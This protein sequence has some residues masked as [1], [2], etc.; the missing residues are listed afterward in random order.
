M[1]K[2]AI[3]I[4]VFTVLL[5][6]PTSC[7]TEKLPSYAVAESEAFKS[8]KDAE[9]FSAGIYAFLRGRITGIFMEAR[10]IQ[11]DVLNATTD[12]G[13]YEGQLHRWVFSS[14]EYTIGSSTWYPYYQAIA[15]INAFLDKINE[16]TPQNAEEQSIFNQCKGEAFWARAY[17]Y[18]KLVKNHAKDYEPSSASSDLGVPLTLHLDIELKPSRATVEETYQQISSDLDSAK[19]Y[20]NLDGK[21]GSEK[22]SKDCVI[23]L[24]ARTA[25]EMHQ[26]STA[27]SLADQLIE[28]GTYPL[29]SD[30]ENFKQ[31]WHNDAPQESILQLYASSTEAV[32][33]IG[34]RYLG[35]VASSGK[36]AP[37]YIPQ[38]WV[39][40]LFAP[41]DIRL[42][43]FIAQ[44]PVDL[45][46]ID[47]T[48]YLL[49][50]FPGNPELFTG[51]VTNYRHKPK[52]MRIAEMYLIKAEALAWNNEDSPALSALNQLRTKRGLAELTGISGEALKTAI[53][54]ERTRE[55]LCEGVRMDDLK[56]W[57]DDCTRKTPQCMNAVSQTAD[58][59]QLTK[60]AGHTK[61]V[62]AI[63]ANEMQT[64]PNLK[65]QQNP[66]WDN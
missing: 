36:Y 65:G 7:E 43:V 32:L 2:I 10:D 42:G 25:L 35:Y 1:K 11:A 16:I 29:V 52:V 19:F 57:K 24:Q 62:W 53:K 15:K 18:S 56:R 13:N 40:D 58:T 48:L 12:F 27:A 59:Y 33:P 55:M 30:A 6:M 37:S 41:Q 49:N 23:A 51:T 39:V 26:Y 4:S 66:G 64:N 22:I 17:Y 63:P 54:E 34:Q 47:T 38:Q 44:L 61:F 46:L 5:V 8:V 45:T 14:S 28:S 21:E 9:S 31:I 50:K 60:P 20:V 3:I